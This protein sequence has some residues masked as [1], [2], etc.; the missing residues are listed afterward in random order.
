MEAFLFSAK[1]EKA[2]K[3]VLLGDIR[4]KETMK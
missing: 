1:L 3:D 4:V 2:I